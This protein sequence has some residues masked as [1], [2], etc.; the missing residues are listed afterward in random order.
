M[1]QIPV[2]SAEG[3]HRREMFEFGHSGDGDCVFRKARRLRRFNQRTERGEWGT[4]L[5]ATYACMHPKE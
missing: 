3:G 5:Q 4:G 1:V 2:R